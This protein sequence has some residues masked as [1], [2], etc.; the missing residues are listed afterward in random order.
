MSELICC[1]NAQGQMICR[2]MG[3]P[4]VAVFLNGISDYYQHT[5]CEGIAKR[6]EELGFSVLFFASRLNNA[7]N[8]NNKGELKLFTLPDMRGFDGIIVATNTIN[9]IE[10]VEYLKKSLPL[11]SI[12]VVNIGAPINGSFSVDSIDN[13]CM[14]TVIRHFIVQHRFTR[15]NFIS[16]PTSNPD[17]Q[18]RLDIYKKVLSE[19]GIEYD[20]SRVFIGDFSRECARDAIT[21]FLSDQ[22]D[23]PQ[24][25]VCVNDNLALGAY[26]ELTRRGLRVPEDIALSGY[27]CVH[28]AEYHLPRITTVKQPLREM[29]RRAVQIINDINSGEHVQRE[30]MYDSEVV[31]AGSCGCTDA[32]PIEERQLVEDLALNLDDLRFYN[33]TSAS[34]MELLTGTYTM[35]DVVNQLTN[36]SRSL[37]FKHLYF[38]VDEG[39]LVNQT[40][41][42]AA[43]PDEMTLMLGIVNDTVYTDL[44]FKT[45]D[46]LPPLDQDMIAL[47]FAPLYYKNTTFGYI[48]FDFNHSSS[49]MHRIWVK[50]VRLALENLRTQHALKQYAVAL[51][52]ISLH[53]PLTGVLNR[54]GLEKHAQSLTRT[55][56]K[57]MLFAIF[58]DL[59]GL[60]RINDAYGH[61]AGDEAIQV[62]AEILRHCSRPGDIIARMGGD[63]FVCI[64]LVPDEETL[65]AMLFSMQSYGKLYNDRSV[66]PYAVNASYGWC[67]Q[68]LDEN[69]SIMQMIDKADSDLYE[70]K[71]MRSQR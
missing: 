15:I 26:A 68:P 11:D 62:I 41:N 66:K 30:Y 17:V 21:R 69:L 33:E 65:R 53:D 61:A 39:S 9:S 64:G 10:T 37:A 44:R 18:H 3:R 52:E 42:S 14:A 7:V 60:K 29:G 70:Q 25:I 40:G 28:D 67:L 57:S 59:D 5:L 49:F 16:G 24:A 46:I 19:Y 51:E 13:G 20:E 2:A 12:P 43:Y 22:G 27:D 4:R 6:A 31:I 45:K 38:C 36:L 35:Q 8:E 55:N 63:E 23:L 48:A 34:M 54:R 50:N 71:R 1:T 47:V 32:A 58:V 56:S